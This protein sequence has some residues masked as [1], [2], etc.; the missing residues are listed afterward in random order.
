[1]S[2]IDLDGALAPPPEV[3]PNFDHPEDVFGTINMVTQILSIAV[4]TPIVLLRVLL[5][6]G[7]NIT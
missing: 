5:G 1:M 3:I 6:Q 2:D 4:L 7:F